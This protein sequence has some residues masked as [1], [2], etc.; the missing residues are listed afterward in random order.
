MSFNCWLSMWIVPTSGRV[1][2]RRVDA[3]VD[4]PDP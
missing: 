4:F 1:I 2:E 3:R